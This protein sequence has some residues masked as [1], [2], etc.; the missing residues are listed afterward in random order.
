MSYI[1]FVYLFVRGTCVVHIYLC[2]RGA[3]IPSNECEGIIKSCMHASCNNVC[4]RADSLIIYRCVRA[5][6]VWSQV[7]FSSGAT[8]IAFS[9]IV[10][11]KP[12]SKEVEC[13]DGAIINWLE[14]LVEEVRAV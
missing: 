1:S 9:L 7:A 5:V 3:H 14:D 6:R 4:V 10:I 8:A 13:G 11:L 12:F 2:V